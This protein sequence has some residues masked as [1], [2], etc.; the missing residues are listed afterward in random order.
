MLTER[1]ICSPAIFS[2]A[3]VKPSETAVIERSETEARVHDGCNA[4]AN[5]W[6][7]PGWSGHSRGIDSAGRACLMHQVSTTL[8]PGFPWLK[9]PI[10]NWNTRLV[11][12]ADAAEG[13]LVAQGY[14]VEGATTAPATA[15]LELDA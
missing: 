6:Q 14:E 4:A 12:V 9:P 1:P 13:R 15:P 10:R 5:H 11:M 8:D 3:G 7:A 2:L